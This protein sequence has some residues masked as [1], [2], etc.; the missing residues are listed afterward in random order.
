MPSAA[1]AS[2]RPKETVLDELSQRISKLKNEYMKHLEA[3]KVKA[4]AANNEQLCVELENS[5]RDILASYIRPIEEVATEMAK[6]KAAEVFPRGPGDIGIALPAISKVTLER[7]IN[8]KR[9][10]VFKEI[11][12]TTGSFHSSWVEKQMISDLNE[13]LDN[14]AADVR[15]M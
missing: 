9:N 10:A 14:W 15:G 12:T 11:N 5:M 13:D 7:A 6:V 8:A 4:T 1:E 2:I 3:A